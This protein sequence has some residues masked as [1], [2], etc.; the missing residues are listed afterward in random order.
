MSLE[1]SGYDLCASLCVHIPC[2]A[3]GQR[4]GC[5]NRGAAETIVLHPRGSGTGLWC[6][7][8]GFTFGRGRGEWEAGQ[9]HDWVP[10]I[11]WPQWPPISVCCWHQS[12]ALGGQMATHTGG[13]RQKEQA[14]GTAQPAPATPPGRR[15]RLGS[16]SVK[17]SHRFL[18]GSQNNLGIR[19]LHGRNWGSARWTTGP[20][21]HSS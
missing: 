5:V 17:A 13:K 11:Q 10:R 16:C 2:L 19:V 8:L 4:W 15:Q 9:G 1:A 6:A 18:T 20:R 7:C 21:P 12:G 3:A 14:L